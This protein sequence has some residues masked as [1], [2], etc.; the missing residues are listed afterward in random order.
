MPWS[1]VDG[2][3]DRENSPTA[4]AI[5]HQNSISPTVGDRSP[6]CARS[7]FL[8]FCY[9]PMVCRSQNFPSSATN[10]A[11]GA[12]INNTSP[13]NRLTNNRPRLHRSLQA[14]P[15]ITEIRRSRRKEPWQCAELCLRDNTRRGL[16]D[17]QCQSTAR[18]EGEHG[19]GDGEIQEVV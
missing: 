11:L 3:S 13:H 8:P 7:L 9:T 12:S 1:E 5:K 17:S 18:W 2:S 4:N 19:A 15:S 14:S 6:S 10:N 16:Q